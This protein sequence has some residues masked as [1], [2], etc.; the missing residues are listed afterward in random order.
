MT[1][2]LRLLRGPMLFALLAVLAGCRSYEYVPDIPSEQFDPQQSLGSLEVRFPREQRNPPTLKGSFYRKVLDP[3]MGVAGT[4]VFAIVYPTMQIGEDYSALTIE[5]QVLGDGHWRFAI[6]H[7][8][9]WDGPHDLRLRFPNAQIHGGQTFLFRFIEGQSCLN[10]YTLD[11]QG[12]TPLQISVRFK[13]PACLLPCS[14]SLN[15]P[16]KCSNLWR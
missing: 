7:K 12:G 4:Y 1:D 14:P 6:P 16:A 2:S 8:R 15:D 11:Q 13:R 3:E 5:G 10:D 9:G